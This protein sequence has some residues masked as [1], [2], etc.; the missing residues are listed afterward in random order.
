[1]TCLDLPDRVLPEKAVGTIKQLVGDDS[2]KS[3]PKGMNPTT[4]YDK[5]LLLCAGNHP[6][7]IPRMSQEQA[8]L[9]RMVVIPFLNPVPDEA[10]QQQLYLSLL[11]EAPCIVREPLIAFQSLAKRNF[12]VTQVEI[13]EEY[14][15]RDGR[16]NYQAI[17]T[18]VHERCVPDDKATTSTEHLYQHFV[19]WSGLRP[20]LIDFSRC[21][22]DILVSSADI[23]LVKRTENGQ[24]GY[25]GIRLCNSAG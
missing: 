9:N 6:I 11:E 7:R 14:E 17:T 5:P 15:P 24:R 19:S 13:P 3:E 21:L 18:F 10:A 22:S 25:R 1:M 23:T 20:S 8:L 2:M 16:S 4:F 12:Q